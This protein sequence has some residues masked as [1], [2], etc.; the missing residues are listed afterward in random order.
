[1]WRLNTATRGRSDSQ[2]QVSRRVQSAARQAPPLSAQRAA[3]T[4]RAATSEAAR[5][6]RRVR[7]GGERAGACQ[8]DRR[9]ASPV[10]TGWSGRWV[11][12]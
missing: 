8:V 3:T 5:T 6:V 2:E 10:A 9:A 11:T 4:V 1:M 12:D 7:G